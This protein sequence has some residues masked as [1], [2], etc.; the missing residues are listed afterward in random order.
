MNKI[1][2]FMGGYFPG[3]N[4]GGPPVSVDNF[5]T[6]LIDVFDVFIV[7]S[8]HDLGSNNKYNV[9]LN[10]VNRDNCK[11][12]YISDS[13]WRLDTLS[14]I[15]KKISPDVIYLQS[16]FRL[17][18]P[19]C[20]ILAK[21]QRIPVILAPRGELCKGALAIKRY[22]K[23]PYLLL[24]KVL[25]LTDNTIFQSTSE[26]EEQGIRKYF[27]GNVILNLNNIPSIPQIEEKKII[28]AK[29]IARFV[30]ISRIVKKKN[31]STAISFF[32]KINSGRVTFDIYG[33][34]EDTEYWTLCCKLI[35]SAPENVSINYKGVIQH[36]DVHKVLLKYDAMLFPTLSENYGHVIA[37]ALGVGCPVII[38]DQT[39]WNEVNRYKAGAAISLS[40][41]KRFI[42][43]IYR[44]INMDEK[45]SEEV[46]ENS[47]R[48]FRDRLQLEKLKSSYS[49]AFKNAI[50]V[51]K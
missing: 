32:S 36:D 2:I 21:R 6:L 48:L 16:I 23:L 13:Q 31:L 37:E 47:K 44:V 33:A 25:R 5:C 12:K 51:N 45:E 7:T 8:D 41:E 3:Q 38:S 28:K 29:G 39:P 24:L 15:I 46:S 4:Y 43:A 26:D 11:V 20:L 19:L 30:F 34:I 50:S 14:D 9:G 27:N 35:E 22:K 1:L 18:T 42:N 10:W 40:D 17:F 49:E